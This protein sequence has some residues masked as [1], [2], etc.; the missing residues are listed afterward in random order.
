[1]RLVEQA[2]ASRSRAQAL[3]DRAALLLTV[4]A[5]VAGTITLVAS[6]QGGSL[7]ID[8]VAVRPGHPMLLARQPT[9]AWLVGLPG[10]PGAAIAG[11]LTLLRPLVAGMLGR[12]QPGRR[13]MRVASD[14][15]GG[16]VH[17]LEPATETSEQVLP[18]G[19]AGAGRLTGWAV[20]SHAIL[21]PPGGVRTGESIDT[22]RLP[23]Y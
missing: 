4:V 14:I 20:G 11:V 18:C 15:P 13:H 16:R 17:R 10:N 8:Q 1:M 3:A 19:N 5:I 2:Q 7:V 23:S 22:I 6:H 12:A 9:G 21:V